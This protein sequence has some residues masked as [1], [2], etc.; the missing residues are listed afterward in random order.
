DGNDRVDINAS[1]AVSGAIIIPD[2][3]FIQNSIVQ[4]PEFLINPE[5]LLANSCI[6]PNQNRGGS[7]IIKGSGGVQN[8]P[9]DMN[10]PSYF[11]EIIQPIPETP[12]QPWKKGDP[13]IEP[14]GVYYTPDGR[15][16][17]SRKC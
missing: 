7:F 11:P 2:L 10:T 4:L 6:S 13:I 3:T 5:K 16:Y 12:A 15:L 8:R 14:Q 1:G 17:L 9:G